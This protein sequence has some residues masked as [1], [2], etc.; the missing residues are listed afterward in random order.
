[1][2]PH[3]QQLRV[4][5]ILFRV[6]YLREGV[7]SIE[8]HMTK[9]PNLINLYFCLLLFQCTP[10]GMHS[11]RGFCLRLIDNLAYGHFKDSKPFYV[12]LALVQSIMKLTHK[13]LPEGADIPQHLNTFIPKN[14]NSL[15]E[16]LEVLAEDYKNTFLKWENAEQARKYFEA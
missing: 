10:Q 15:I 14:F 7:T 1:M 11:R 6:K 2:P 5:S 3:A 16:G 4:I 8:E 12:Y 9:K 13:T